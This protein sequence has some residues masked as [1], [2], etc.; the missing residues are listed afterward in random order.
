MPEPVTAP[1]PRRAAPVPVP[2][3]TPVDTLAEPVEPPAPPVNRVATVTPIQTPA[4][5]I[6]TEP[7]ADEDSL[8]PA[9]APRL[10]TVEELGGRIM[11]IRSEGVSIEWSAPTD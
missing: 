7:E 2:P 8:P 5:E 10:A 6:A 9:R 3:G 11:S 1:L 4:A